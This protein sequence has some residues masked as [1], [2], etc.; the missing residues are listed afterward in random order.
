MWPPVVNFQ[1]HMSWLPVERHPKFPEMPGYPV[2]HTVKQVDSPWPWVS[3]YGA[4]RG[5]LV[6]SIAEK[7]A[8]RSL[9]A[10]IV[11]PTRAD[12]VLAPDADHDHHEADP[13]PAR[14]RPSH[15][16]SGFKTPRVVTGSLL[17]VTTPV[18]RPSA[19]STTVTCA[20]DAA[21]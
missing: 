17:T 11:V 14:M 1:I 8:L 20:S 18:A 2:S 12:R 19:L 3:T 9:P 7:K 4:H 6:P 13:M 10:S 21:Q 15:H 16:E 5:L